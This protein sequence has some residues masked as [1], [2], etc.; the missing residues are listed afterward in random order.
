MTTVLPL[1]NGANAAVELI[2]SKWESILIL[3]IR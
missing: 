2:R 1:F 3:A